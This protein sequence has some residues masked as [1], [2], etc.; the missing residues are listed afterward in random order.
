[1]SRVGSIELFPE[2]NLRQQKVPEIGS[3]SCLCWDE[4]EGFQKGHFEAA[5]LDPALYFP[6]NPLE[7]LQELGELRGLD[8]LVMS[9]SICAS[10]ITTVYLIFEDSLF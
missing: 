5:F 8:H 10:K 2:I 7:I 9:G 1:M 3:S 4:Q 6:G